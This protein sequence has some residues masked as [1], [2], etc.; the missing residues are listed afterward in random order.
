M[1]KAAIY[2][3][4]STDEHQDMSLEL[5][6][7]EAKAFCGS[8]GCSVDDRHMYEDDAVSRAEFKKRHGLAAMLNAAKRREFDVVVVRDETRLGGDQARTALV[9]QDLLDSGIKLYYY[10]TKEE[11]KLDGAVSRFMM[12]ARLFASELERE[13]TAE[14]TREHLEYKARAGANVGGRCYG[15]DNVDVVQNERRLR[16]DY[17]VN[18]AEAEIISEVFSR[19]ARGVGLKSIAKDLNRRGIASPRAGKRGTGSWSP[20]SMYEMLRRDRYRGVLIWGREGTA[21][22][23]GTQVRVHHGQED[24]V[25]AEKPELRIVS[26]ELWTAVQERIAQ[27]VKV[28]GRAGPKGPKPRYLLTGIARC[29][30]CGGPIHASNGKSGKTTIKVYSCA[31]HR[32]RGD[33]VC[34]N[35]LRR[36]VEGVD[37]AVVKWVEQNVLREGIVL[38]TIAEVRRRLSSKD[39]SAERE[40]HDLEDHIKKLEREIRKAT[41]DLFDSEF[42]PKSVFQAIHDREVQVAVAMARVQALRAAPQI[43]EGSLSGLE[44]EARRRL[45]D[46]RGL[47][48]ANP[49]EG[50]RVL[51][52]VLD[53]PLTFTPM[54]MADGAKRYLVTGK[55]IGAM[56]MFTTGGDPNGIRTRVHGLKGHCPGPD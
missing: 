47:I 32:D 21:Y 45:A 35:S 40:I 46:L 30:A 19:Y 28:I 11:V 37:E 50:R 33:S 48:K 41:D 56:A 51:E 42:K 53:G 5:Q 1:N 44:A 36:P 13:K 29:S 38:E 24:W 4:R 15:Y 7:N 16:V 31:R 22:K 2:T 18:E 20:G 43:L 14:R 39:G 26:E 27:N 54:T 25:V 52:S 17:K 34:K 6:Q 10:F 8:L 55:T 9:I 49:D 12:N 3:R 23:G